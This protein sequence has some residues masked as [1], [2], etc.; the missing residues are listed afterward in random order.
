MGHSNG[1]ITP[2]VN[3]ADVSYVTR[4]GSNDVGTLCGNNP[5]INKWAKYKPVIYHNLIDTT[6]QLNSDKTWKSTATWWKA[7]DGKCGLTI[8]KRTN[9]SA[10]VTNW[11][12]D[13]TYNP[14]TGG[15]N[16]P[17][18]LIDFN[19]YDHNAHSPL[20]IS[21]PLQYVINQSN[22]LNVVF[23]AYSGNDK[24]LML[25]DVTAGVWDSTKQMYCGVLVVYG[26]LNSSYANKTKVSVVHPT[27]L[28]T[29]LTNYGK[30]VREVSVPF[31]DMPTYSGS[32]IMIYPFLCQNGYAEQKKGANEDITWENG[33][34]DCPFDFA[35]IYAVSAWITGVL[36]S[37]TC[38]YNINSVQVAFNYTLTG[39]N[40]FVKEGVMPYLYILDN[41]IDTVGKYPDNEKKYGKHIISY[42]SAPNNPKVGAM[43]G[44]NIPDG[45][46][47]SYTQDVLFDNSSPYAVVGIDAASYVEDYRSR[48]GSGAAKV[49]LVMELQDSDGIY[50]SATLAD[51][52][53]SG[54]Y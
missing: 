12:T 34:I 33:V 8:T 4:R 24:Q 45:T 25:T 22:N 2:P 32:E 35:T 42:G 46:T 38:N 15:M 44:I 20:Y 5:M 53:I 10:L 3:T 30:Y 31:G 28:G 48:H 54:T 13:W 49:T 52:T 29:D 51:V 47:R 21:Y 19:Y 9:G 14:P 16:A 23:Q 43:F 40:G 11:G 17:Y 50:G 6:G 39:H 36:S 27:P 37:V 41:D 1:I 26:I 18:R 7:S